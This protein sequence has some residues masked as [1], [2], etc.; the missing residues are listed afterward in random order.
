MGS[1]STVAVVV[2]AP[3]LA[4]V[5]VRGN[6]AP[7]AW[8][9]TLGTVVIIGGMLAVPFLRGANGYLAVIAL[10]NVLVTITAIY[11]DLW[12]GRGVRRRVRTEE[13]AFQLES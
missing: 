12:P 11:I 7:I 2:A 4:S 5:R 8:A 6:Y 9:R 1:L 3:W 13:P 10:Q